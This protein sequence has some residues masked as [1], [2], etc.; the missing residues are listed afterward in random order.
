MM[1]HT[2][3]ETWVK[4]FKVTTREV[5]DCNM[6]VLTSN[7]SMC[8]LIVDRNFS[9]LR[10]TLSFEHVPCFSDSPYQIRSS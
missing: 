9:F 3:T 4:I 2:E 1:I 8:M 6:L 10:K 5:K 7:V